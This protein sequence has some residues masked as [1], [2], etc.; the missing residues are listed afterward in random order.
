M[1]DLGDNLRDMAADA[2]F[3]MLEALWEAEKDRLDLAEVKLD[4]AS[5]A[6]SNMLEALWEAE[7]E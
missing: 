2:M 1:S 3:F 7:E 5:H 4:E 6:V